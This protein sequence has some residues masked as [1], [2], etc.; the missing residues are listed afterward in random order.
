MQ[1]LRCTLMMGLATFA[2][3]AQQPR[4]ADQPR[5]MEIVLEQQVGK[6]S[7]VV[8]PQHVFKTGDRVRFRFRSSFNGYLYVTDRAA[9]GKYLTLF[10]AEGAG[11]DNHLVRGKDYLIP[12]TADSWFRIDEPAGYETVFFVVT[13]SRLGEKSGQTPPQAPILA[14]PPSEPLPADLLPRCD[15]AIFRA[16]G[17]CLDANAG[18]GALAPQEHPTDANSNE[19]LTPREIVVIRKTDSSVVAPATDGDTPIIY[20][21]RIAHR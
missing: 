11:T 3:V 20:Q 15:D 5:K 16:R 13:P 7:R 10:P 21:F 2:C 4:A 18:A 1:A 14:P 12:S 17:E 8:N 19:N 6:T 9:S